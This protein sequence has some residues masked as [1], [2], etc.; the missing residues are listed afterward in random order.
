[1]SGPRTHY[2]SPY[3]VTLYR[4]PQTISA[5]R[6][7]MTLLWN[8]FVFEPFVLSSRSPLP[9]G[10]RRLVTLLLLVYTPPDG[11]STITDLSVRAFPY[12]T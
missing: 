12:S 3:S 2:I 11:L 10:D 8:V 1:M 6:C 5:A 9:W 4:H 7:G